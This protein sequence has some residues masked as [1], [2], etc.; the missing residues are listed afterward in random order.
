MRAL[1]GFRAY[2]ILGVVAIHLLGA[3]G[4]FAA[5]AGTATAVVLWLPLGNT[6]DAFF[7]I[8]AFVLFLPVIRRGGAFGSRARFWIGRGVRLFPAYW[9]ALVGYIQRLPLT[10]FED[11]ISSLGAEGLLRPTPAPD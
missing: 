5:T 10:R 3:S 2:A 7:I 1:D 4:V 11:Y 8:S 9:L 6:I